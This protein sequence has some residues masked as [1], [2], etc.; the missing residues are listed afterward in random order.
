MRTPEEQLHPETEVADGLTITPANLGKLSILAAVIAITLKLIGD[1]VFDEQSSAVT[2][3][4][5][6]ASMIVGG[7]IAVAIWGLRR[8]WNCFST[9]MLL[10]G[11]VGLFLNGGLFAMGFVKLPMPGQFGLGPVSVSGRVTN[12]GQVSSKRGIAVVTQE[13]TAG[14]PIELTDRNFED[15]VNNSNIPVLV[16]FWAPWC[17]PCRML[18]PVIERIAEKY[19]GKVKVCKLNVDSSRETPA[20]F[21]VR[22][23]PTIIL[24]KKGRVLNKWVGLTSERDICSAIDRQL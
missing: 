8:A 4:G 21:K 23:I 1:A 18:G 14:Y 19:E 5:I 24:F 15:I 2:S 7:G 3:I 11:G 13:W 17:G 6:A 12:V 22:G 10:L 9:D 16:D 20:S